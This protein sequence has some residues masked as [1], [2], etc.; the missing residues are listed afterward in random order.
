MM[1]MVHIYTITRGLQIRRHSTVTYRSTDDLAQT[2]VGKAEDRDFSHGRVVAQGGLHLA[3]VNVLATA[4][5][6]VFESVENVSVWC[7]K[8]VDIPS[9]S[10]AYAAM[11]QTHMAQ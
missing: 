5:D 1:M 10:F 6:Q 11:L 8:W 7:E 2:R 3:A 9:V 4:N